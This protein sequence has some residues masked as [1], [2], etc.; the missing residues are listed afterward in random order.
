[1]VSENGLVATAALIRLF[2][3]VSKLHLASDNCVVPRIEIL[4]YLPCT[5]RFQS[6]GRLLVERDLTF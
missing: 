3:V 1:M 4:T 5:L 6:V 2:E